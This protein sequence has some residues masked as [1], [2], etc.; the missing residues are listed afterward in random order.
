MGSGAG[1]WL[2]E[3][4]GGRVR[5]FPNAFTPP[6]T[7]SSQTSSTALCT[8]V[9]STVGFGG[10]SGTH[11]HDSRSTV[12]PPHHLPP[13]VPTSQVKSTVGFGGGLGGSGTPSGSSGAA[14][15]AP[16]LQRLSA[17]LGMKSPGREKEKE[18]VGEG[19]VCVCVCGW[20][21]MG[22]IGENGS[23]TSPRRERKGGEVPRSSSLFLFS[24]CLGPHRSL[25]AAAGHQERPLPL[26]VLYLSLT[27]SH[28]LSPPLSLPHR[29]LTAA[30]GPLEGPTGHQ[31]QRNRRA[32]PS[33]SP[34]P[35]TAGLW[36]R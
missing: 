36:C 23:G 21:W 24:S 33:T 11:T 27:P 10:G 29:L 25:T 22:A 18:K 4:S 16:L 19:S 8:Q 26:L 17:G 5:T 3:V 2:P 30:A 31:C 32:R 20:V 1:W 12:F 15:K 14:K 9:K 35:P 13:G 6:L 7:L 34:W 28:P